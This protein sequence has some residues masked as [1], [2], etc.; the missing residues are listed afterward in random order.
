[1]SILVI[2]AEHSSLF[3]ASIQCPEEQSE[4]QVLEGLHEAEHLWSHLWDVKQA[5]Q[6]IEGN[7]KVN[8]KYQ[9]THAIR[10]TKATVV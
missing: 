10:M 5:F 3:L 6:R 7:A 2:T 8:H 9:Y 4:N 1:M